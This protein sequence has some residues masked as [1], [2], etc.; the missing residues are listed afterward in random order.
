MYFRELKAYFS[1]PNDVE[2]DIQEYIALAY[3]NTNLVYE[4]AIS[5]IVQLMDELLFS[6]MSVWKQQL[7]NYIGT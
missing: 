3:D 5:R 1:N 6:Q 7:W 4:V 2:D